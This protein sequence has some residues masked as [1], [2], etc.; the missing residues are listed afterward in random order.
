MGIVDDVRRAAEQTLDKALPDRTPLY[1]LTG[2]G[3][4]A[5]EKLRALPDQVQDRLEE[6]RADYRRLPARS[7][8]IAFARLLEFNVR[9]AEMLDDLGRRGQPI[10]DARLDRERHGKH[11]D[12]RDDGDDDRPARERPAARKTTARKTTARKTTARK[13]TARKTTT[14][15]TT[16]RKT[17]AGK[18]TARKTTARRP[19]A[20]D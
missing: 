3:D 7:A 2:A 19:A 18:G 13:T 6:L 12:D 14:R 16:A 9:A 20:G 8:A 10:V 5:A 15:K 4:L 11:D 1:L 17:T